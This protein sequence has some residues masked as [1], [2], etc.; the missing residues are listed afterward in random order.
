MDASSSSL[1]RCYSGVGWPALDCKIQRRA[2][3]RRVGLIAQYSLCSAKPLS[4]SIRTKVQ[5]PSEL[6][7]LGRDSVSSS[8]NKQLELSTCR[9]LQLQ[10]IKIAGA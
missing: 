1:A 8:S 7:G 9:E 4:L 2:V 6:W 3:V 10:F 5:S